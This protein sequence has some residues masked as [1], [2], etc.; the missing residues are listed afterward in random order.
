MIG[1]VAFLTQ[2]LGSVVIWH[3]AEM[4]KIIAGKERRWEKINASSGSAMLC[5]HAEM[6][7]GK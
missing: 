7:C 6:A 2:R 3:L 4:I 5:K 1:F